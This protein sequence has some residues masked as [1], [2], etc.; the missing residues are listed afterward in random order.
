[1]NG[2]SSFVVGLF[3]SPRSAP[4]P[5]GRVLVSPK[6]LLIRSWPRGRWIRREVDQASATCVAV[7]SNWQL[8][9][10][11]IERMPGVGIWAPLGLG[12]IVSALR[13]NGY[14]VVTDP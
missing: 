13:S 8:P 1:M 7:R 4:W 14:R 5:F 3:D 11:S 9:T 2:D 12:P 10:L 6:R